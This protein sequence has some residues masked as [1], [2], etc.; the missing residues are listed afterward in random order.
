[1]SRR[2]LART[3]VTYVSGS[4]TASPEHLDGGLSW[5]EDTLGIQ[6]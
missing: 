2:S 3:T 5:G 1:M 6:F 4:E